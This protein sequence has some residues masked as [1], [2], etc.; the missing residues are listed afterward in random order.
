MIMAGAGTGKT[1]TLVKRIV[2]LIENK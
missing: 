2:H 1:F